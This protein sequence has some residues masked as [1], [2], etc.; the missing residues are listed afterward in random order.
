M[1]LHDCVNPL[2]VRLIDPASAPAAPNPRTSLTTTP[3]GRSRLSLAERISRVVKL[4]E[5]RCGPCMVWFAGVVVT[6]LDD[7]GEL[8][9]EVHG[10]APPVVGG[11]AD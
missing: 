4:G 6:G 3:Q 1:A 10:V 5:Q 7:G 8:A 9:A 11:V 2:C